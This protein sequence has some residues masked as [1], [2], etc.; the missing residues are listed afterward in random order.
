MIKRGKREI[1]RETRVKEKY[2]K[3]QNRGQKTSFWIGRE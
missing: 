1:Y 2:E 3:K